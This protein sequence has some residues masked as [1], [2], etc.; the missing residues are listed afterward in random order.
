MERLYII[1]NGFDMHHD[2]PSGF[3]DFKSYV[4]DNDSQLLQMLDEYFDHDSLW[5]DFERTLAWIDVDTILD[6]A[7]NFLESYGSDDW[8]DADHHR[9]G[10]EIDRAVGLVTGDL[11]GR[12]TEWVLQLDISVE[13]IV[14]LVAKSKFL[15][16]NYTLTLEERYGIP[17]EN[18]FHIHNAIGG[19]NPNLILGHAR[20]FDEQE[21]Y[22][23]LNDEETDVR[24]A[25][26]N[27][28]IDQYFRDTHKDSMTLIAENDEYFKGLSD[29]T[30]VFVL[31]HSISDVDIVY[32]HV[33]NSSVQ[34]DAVWKV[35][36]YSESKIDELKQA[37]I[38][39]GVPKE[40][41]EMITLSELI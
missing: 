11:F 35:S 37:L 23:S 34:K 8:S 38:G 27:Y 30:E 16:F 17:K 6:D 41:I 40:N 24:V 3:W 36:Y 22:A 7:T 26:G 15:T 2:I 33:I 10:Q 4:E 39:V 12:F 20:E 29:V 28:A 18:V 14:N 9:Y 21:T 25:E 31:G 13:P 1:G 5:N 19:D 32:F